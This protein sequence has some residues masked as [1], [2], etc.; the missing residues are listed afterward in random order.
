MGIVNISVVII[1]KEWVK[2]NCSV[3]VVV[4]LQTEAFRILLNSPDRKP[5]VT[6]PGC[7]HKVFS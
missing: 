7:Q 3:S 2:L 1:P 5:V 4:Q 6:E